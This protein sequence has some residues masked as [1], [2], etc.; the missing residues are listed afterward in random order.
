MPRVKNKETK[1]IILE[2]GRELFSKNGYHDTNVASIIHK[3]G[4]AHGSFYNYFKS[5]FE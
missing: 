1:D 4:M 3:A 2:A 5:K